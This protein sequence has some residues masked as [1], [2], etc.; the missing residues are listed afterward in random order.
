MNNHAIHPLKERK[1]RLRS[2]YKKLRAEISA[3]A[4][5]ARDESICQSALALV[6]FRYA[7]IVLLY[8]P[9]E[10]EINI[11]P[12]AEAALKKGKKIAFPRCDAASR[13]MQYHFVQSL[14]DL[15]VSTYGIRE[16]DAALP[17]YDQS[18]HTDSAVCFIPGLVY[19][20][21]GYRLGYGKGFYDRY[22]SG[23][24]GCRIGVIYSDCIIPEVPR[25]RY[26]IRA[27]ILLTEKNVRVPR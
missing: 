19:D 12:I 4:R 11:L 16:P 5:A 6:S 23:F 20:Q 14:S 10:Q 3:E 26:D 27:D 22:L 25:G 15:T 18:V 21:H 2:Q 8:A 17:I 9:M 1:D 7:D 24:H 13:T